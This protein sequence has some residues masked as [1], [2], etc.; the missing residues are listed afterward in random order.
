MLVSP[1]FCR[2]FLHHNEADLL[3]GSESHHEDLI[4]I[5]SIRFFPPDD[6]YKKAPDIV[7]GLRI[8]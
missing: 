7:W 1:G 3:S 8:H 4:Q 6:R 2:L 5:A